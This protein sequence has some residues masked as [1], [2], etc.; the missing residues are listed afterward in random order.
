MAFMLASLAACSKVDNNIASKGS[1]GD[2]IVFSSY[3]GRIRT[4]TGVGTALQQSFTVEGFVCGDSTVRYFNAETYRYSNGN[5]VSNVTR[6]WPLNVQRMNFYAVSPL[7]YT[8]TSGVAVALK[9]VDSTFTVNGTDG[10]KDIVA[11]RLVNQEYECPVTLNFGHKLTRIAFMAKGADPSMTYKIDSITVIA[12]STASYNYGPSESWGESSD[13]FAYTFLGENITIP[14]GTLNPQSV[15]DTLYLIPSQGS[16]VKARV[17]YSIYHRKYQIDTTTSAVEIDLPVSDIWGINKSVIYKLTLNFTDSATPV[18]FTAEQGDWNE[19]SPDPSFDIPEFVPVSSIVITPGD[20]TTYLYPKYTQELLAT[21]SPADASNKY[22][23]WSSS[24]EAVATVDS[25]SG[26]V[27]GVSVGTVTITATA[28]DGSGVVG[29][30][31]VTVSTGISIRG[32]VWAPVN[33]GY[34]PVYFPYGMIYQWGRSAGCGYKE[35]Y[36]SSSPYGEDAGGLVQEYCETP[37]S[38]TIPED[39]KFYGGGQPSSSYDNFNWYSGTPFTA[40]PMNDPVNGIGNPCPAG[41]RVPS[42]EELDKLVGGDGTGTGNPAATIVD[43]SRAVPVYWL[44]GTSNPS[45]NSSIRLMLPAA[46]WRFPNDWGTGRGRTCRRG[47]I[48]IYWSS[49][50]VSD[51]V[52]AKYLT[53]DSPGGASFKPHGRAWGHYVRCVAE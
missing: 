34:D 29:T 27:T 39:D 50:A 53:V 24:D 37:M 21:V 45:K 26:V 10:T 30:A 20:T 31:N 32:S 40:W 28:D 9:S 22:V 48:C 42:L 23:K 4:K 33:C 14:A 6:Y 17:R 47:D 15:G 18:V 49:T 51:G 41:W 12:N 7:Q 13:A 3:L 43:Y 35:Y 52:H 36:N 25:L 44:D 11:S 16:T 8:N 1:N 46:G 5:Y 38:T 19:V 2:E